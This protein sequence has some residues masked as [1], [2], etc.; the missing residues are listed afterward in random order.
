[1][2][3]YMNKLLYVD[4]SESKFEIRDLNIE[5]A[6]KYV[7]GSGLAAKILYDETNKDTNPLGP[8]NVLIFMTGPFTGTRAL[9]SSRYVVVSKSPLTGIY[10]EA[11]SGGERA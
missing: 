9:S 5:D 3:G 6:R 10:G 11:T 2:N 7:G 8:E 4:L 1:M